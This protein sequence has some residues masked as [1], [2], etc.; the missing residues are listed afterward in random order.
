M[1]LSRFCAA[2][3]RDYGIIGIKVHR[4]TRIHNRMLRTK[5]DEK[6]LQLVEEDDQ[7]NVPSLCTNANTTTDSIICEQQ[8]GISSPVPAC[9][10]K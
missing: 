6:L 10:A 3:Y 5:F 8:T 9:P 1:L 2:D 4:I 7:V